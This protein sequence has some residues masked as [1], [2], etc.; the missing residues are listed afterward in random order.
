MSPAG[1]IFLPR[2]SLARVPSLH[3]L[4]ELILPLDTSGCRTTRIT[5][6]TKGWCIVVYWGTQKL[7]KSILV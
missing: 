3:G 5:S 2:R 7:T 4:D 1:M 6:E